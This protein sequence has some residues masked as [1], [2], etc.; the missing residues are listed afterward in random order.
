[1]KTREKNDPNCKKSIC[2]YHATS[3]P[4]IFF[5]CSFFASPSPQA[6][7]YVNAVGF[8]EDL[9]LGNIIGGEHEGGK[10]AGAASDA[11]SAQAA[12]AA[13]ATTDG[14]TAAAPI[15]PSFRTFNL[16]LATLASAGKWKKALAVSAPM[17]GQ[18]GGGDDGAGIIGREGE[19]Q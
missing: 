17:R 18:S 8:L 6:G 11:E 7:R 2:R 12:A 10:A 4:S 3:L 19:I 5:F 16:V 1:M 9:C 14:A 13:A 15:L